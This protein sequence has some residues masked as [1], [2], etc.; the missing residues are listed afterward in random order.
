MATFVLDGREVEVSE[1]LAVVLGAMPEAVLESFE[2]AARDYVDDEE[3][4]GGEAYHAALA[5]GVFRLVIAPVLV[6]ADSRMATDA[7]ALL[8]ITE[9][10]RAHLA[11]EDHEVDEC[12]PCRM[13]VLARCALETFADPLSLAADD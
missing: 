5:E 8:G 6:T 7:A 9:M 13:G 10:H 12:L 1:E 2:L 11:E 3:D 4:D